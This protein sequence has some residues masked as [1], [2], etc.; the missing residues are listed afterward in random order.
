M[1]RRLTM[2]R[3]TQNRLLWLTLIVC[4]CLLP[5]LAIADVAIDTAN[6]PD[7]AFRAYVQEN[8]DTD[9]DGLLSDAERLAVTELH[10]FDREIASL[11]GMEHFP[12]TTDLD[13][14]FNALTALDVSALTKLETLSCD[15]NRIT[16][17]DVSMCPGLTY[18]SCW[19]NR[20]TSLTLGSLPELQ[21]LNCAQN[22]I[23]SLDVS[24]LP[25]LSFLDCYYNR[26]TSL[27]LGSPT[28]LTRLDCSGNQLTSLNLPEGADI[29]LYAT[30]NVYTVALEAGRTIDLKSL[31]GGFIPSRSHDWQGATRKGSVITVNQ[32]VRQVT[33][34][35][36]AMPGN[37]GECLFTLKIKQPALA[38]TA[39]PKAQSV[40]VGEKVSFSVAA[41]GAGLSYQWQYRD[42]A[43]KAWQNSPAV[44]SNSDCLTLIAT[45]SR[46]GYQYRCK[47]TDGSGKSVL[48]KSATLT[49]L[50]PEPPV[51]AAQP[52]SVTA[53]PGEDAVFKADAT[54][55]DLRYQWQFR[56]SA[57]GKWTN[58]P[59]DT[60]QTDTLTLV[61]TLSRSG[62]QYRC[63]ISNEGGSVTTKTATLTVIDPNAPPVITRQPVNRT[64]ALGKT[65]T[66]SVRATGEELKYQWQVKV[67]GGK[68]KNVS[69]AGCRSNTFKV[70]VTKGRNGYYYRCKIT[71]ANGKTVYSRIV[72]LRVK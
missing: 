24:G 10:V 40:K 33:Y 29:H 27:T 15:N 44:S 43:G 72:R 64:L 37:A 56:R 28:Q 54:G 36:D 9:K 26:L 7:E 60:A 68:W 12:N 13:C 23:V 16:T 66:F 20:I 2:H 11:Q 42:S 1:R 51:I 48:S 38:V 18:L 19:D 22:K 65:A 71:A 32:G 8:I 21:S 52:A 30:D 53:A 41:E 34:R 59:A 58:S 62:Y 50:L 45:A 35:Y 55:E 67:P 63:K 46:S 25:K 17:L 6:F 49:V 14:C 31:P 69:G 39:H 70:K 47:V 3:T 57:T 61:A 5:A 4:L